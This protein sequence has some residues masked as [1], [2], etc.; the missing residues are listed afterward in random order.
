MSALDADVVVVGLGIHGSAAAAELARR[1]VDV[2]AVDRFTPAH[3]R[4]SSHG[5]TRMIRRAYPNPAW[6]DLVARAFDGWSELE[7]ETGQ[8]LVHRTGG[9]YAHRGESQLQGPDCIVVDDRVQMSELM[10]GFE[11]P[12][13]YRAVYDPSA[14]V[15]EAARALA[16]MQESAAARGARLRW[17][18]RAEGWERVPGGV[19]LRTDGGDLRA[20]RLVIAGGSWMGSLVPELAPLLEVWRILTLTAAPGQEA[21]MPPSLGA[22]S[23]DRPEGLV[24]GIPDADGN[25]VKLGVDAGAIWDPEIPVAAPSNEEVNELRSLLGDV[26]PGLDTAPAELAACLYTMTAD[27][28]FVLGPLHRAPEVIVASACSGHGFKFGPAI[29]EALADLATGK[30]RDDLAFISTSRREL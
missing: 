5:R 16:A 9:L 29:G 14:G 7:S 4:G 12:Q 8:T 28:R 23:V 25:G 6:N 27:K 3:S 22:F 2:L 18:V 24:F 11:V 1:G 30:A 17:G 13:G 26:V 15:V 21:G 19:V 20:R 10:P